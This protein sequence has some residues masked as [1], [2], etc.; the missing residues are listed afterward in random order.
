[1]RDYGFYIWT[2]YAAAAAVLLINVLL[3]LHEGRKV[4][5]RLREYYRSRDG[6]R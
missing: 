4:C 2:S 5:R 6:G 1:M 3:P